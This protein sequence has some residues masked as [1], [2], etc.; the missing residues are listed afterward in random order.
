MRQGG[1]VELRRLQSKMLFLLDCVFNKDGIEETAH[2]ARS[3]LH[4]IVHDLDAMSI[5]GED[6][7]SLLVIEY[8]S[9]SSPE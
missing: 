6:S 2:I 1:Q 3:V 4:G 5:R 8:P 7:R 9:G